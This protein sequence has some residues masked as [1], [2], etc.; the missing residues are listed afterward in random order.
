MNNHW[1]EDARTY[2]K[3]IPHI[4]RQR[5]DVSETAW[6]AQ[7]WYNQIHTHQ[8]GDPQIGNNNTKELLLLG[9][10]SEPHIRHPSLGVPQWLG[11]PRETDLESQRDMITRLSQ[12]WRK[13]RL[14]S[15]RTQTKPCDTKTQKKG[16]VTPQKTEPKLPASVGGA[17]VE[18]W[19][20]WGPQQGW[21]HWKVPL[22]L[23]PLGVLHSSYHRARRPQDWV[24]WGQTTTRE[25]VQPHSSTDSWIKALLS[26]ALP[27]S[28]SH[29]SASHQEAYTSLLALS[30]RGQTGEAIKTG[31]QWLKQKPYYGKLITIKKATNQAPEE[32]TR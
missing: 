30:I 9:K 10:G 15:W 4:Q 3:M 21:G 23:N 1:Q 20:S 19:V 17:P 2:Q 25:V 6:G 28:S 32:G 31:S 14:Q 27:I 22:G 11:L 7:S 5:R 29:A 13:Q 16:A 24:S 8:V 18:E 26:K 12:D